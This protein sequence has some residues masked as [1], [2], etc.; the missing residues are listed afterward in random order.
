MQNVAQALLKGEAL[1]GHAAA[2]CSSGV[3]DQ[4]SDRAHLVLI[5]FLCGFVRCKSEPGERLR[6]LSGPSLPGAFRRPGRPT[7]SALLTLRYHDNFKLAPQSKLL[8]LNY[9]TCTCPNCINPDPYHVAMF[10]ALQKA[11]HSILYG[12]EG[13][14]LLSLPRLPLAFSQDITCS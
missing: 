4:L 8:W 1:P 11:R 12:V 2:F 14:N 13:L 3:G 5:L 7:V 6:S 10:A 9:C